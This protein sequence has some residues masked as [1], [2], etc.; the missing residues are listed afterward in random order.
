MLY[1]CIHCP[2]LSRLT[3]SFPDWLLN[4]E[5]K[6]LKCNVCICANVEHSLESA[7]GI[8]SDNNVTR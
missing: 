1:Q 7:T 2:L 4:Q 6:L 8:L 3:S 5:I